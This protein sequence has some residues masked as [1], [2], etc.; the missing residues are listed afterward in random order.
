VVLPTAAGRS[1]VAILAIAD[2][3]RNALIVAPTLDLVR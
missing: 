3:R 1:H 2:R